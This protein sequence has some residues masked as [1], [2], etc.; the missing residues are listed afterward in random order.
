MCK[1]AGSDDTQCFRW[2]ILPCQLTI[3][4]WSGSEVELVALL[5]V[6]M[7]SVSMPSQHWLCWHGTDLG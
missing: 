5:V 1:F 4:S 7:H 2:L 3:M 6:L